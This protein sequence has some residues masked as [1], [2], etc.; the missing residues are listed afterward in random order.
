MYL[1]I[2]VYW[3]ASLIWCL[4]RFLDASVST[5][6]LVILYFFCNLLLFDLEK[7]VINTHFTMDLRTWAL[8]ADNV[9]VA[10]I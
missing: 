9:Q 2:L 1:H 8:K 7:T 6:I 5:V 4:G 10:P 3:G